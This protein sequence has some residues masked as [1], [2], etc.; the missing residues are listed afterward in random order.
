MALTRILQVGIDSEPDVVLVRQRARQICGLL[1]FGVQD[2]VR[3]ATA[4][5]DVARCAY[6]RVSGGRGQFALD[7]RGTVPQLT[8]S[9]RVEGRPPVTS[10]P[11]FAGNLAQGMEQESA[12][13]Q[14]DNAI[15]TAGRLMD[16]CEV[17]PTANNGLTIVMR[18][19]LPAGHHIDGARLARIGA[20][21]AASPVQNTYSEMQQQNHELPARWPSCASAR[22]I[23]CRS[24]ASWKTPT[25][26]WWRCT[27]RSRKRP[28]ACARPTR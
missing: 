19:D 22:T 20:E 12:L 8:V 17:E 5:S 26:A 3:V 2:Q 7:Q 25:A 13:A 4:V 9:I 24:R 6:G 10:A 1:G 15:V 28:S 21:L 16:A 11:A 27:P 23:C 18:K 14:F